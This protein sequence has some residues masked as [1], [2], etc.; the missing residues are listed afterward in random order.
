[1]NPIK[2]KFSFFFKNPFQLPIIL[3]CKLPFF[4]FIRDTA[5]Y[6]NAI[7]FEV[8]FK[9]KILGL[10][11]NRNVY[12]P[13]HSSSKIFDPENIFVGVDTCPGLSKGCYIVGKGGIIIGDYT[14]I[15]PN[16][17]IV[18]TNHDVYDNRQEIEKAINIGK[19][20]WIGA[21]AVILPGITLGDYTIVGAGSIVTKSFTDGYCIIAGNPAKKI[22]DLEKD[23]CMD[24]I[25]EP[26]YYGYISSDKFQEFAKRNLKLKCA[27]L[28]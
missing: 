15:A 27:E 17:T 6:Q 18:S 25:I 24:Y 8:W 14:Q 4:R 13:V 28:A 2:T 23:K 26:K 20:C 12:W 5:K 3:I 22:R 16:V 7:N 11:G 21:N 1:M 19:Y 10:G 9:Q